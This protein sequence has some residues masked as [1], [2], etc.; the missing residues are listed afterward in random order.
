[1]IRSWPLRGI[2]A[3]PVGP[4]AEGADETAASVAGAQGEGF[5]A[6]VRNGAPDFDEAFGWGAADPSDARCGLC[7][8]GSLS[9]GAAAGF[10][11]VAR[12]ISGV[13]SRRWR[14]GQAGAASLRR[15][16]FF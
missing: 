10:L 2:P 7:R 9:L 3:A 15:F 14:L 16:A 1:M 4:D 11:H 12:H 8:A 6:A 5:A 13:H